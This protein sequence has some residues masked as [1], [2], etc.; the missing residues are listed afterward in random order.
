MARDTVSFDA[1]VPVELSLAYADGKFVDGKFGQRVMYSLAFP[2]NHAM[3]LDPGVAQKIGAL[4][5]QP[6]EHF[7]LCK[8]P[9]NGSAPGHWDVWLSP[10]AEQARAH[11][12]TSML[13]RQ[14]AASIQD[15]QAR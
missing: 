15:A 4:Q 13:E 9:K 11:G 5:V 2:E 8:R 3:F 6:G 10:A 7:F 12:E 1:N 14:L